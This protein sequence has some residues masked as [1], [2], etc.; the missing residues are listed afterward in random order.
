MTIG[1]IEVK[2]NIYMGSLRG[3]YFREAKITK[4]KV[5]QTH[6]ILEQECRVNVL[7]LQYYVC[8]LGVCCFLCL[9]SQLGSMEMVQ[10][11]TY[12]G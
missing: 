2:V 6:T 5:S 12:R 10:S 11:S 9:V 1:Y 4:V 8:A 7:V 3:G